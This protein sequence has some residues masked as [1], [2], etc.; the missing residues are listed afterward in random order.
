MALQLPKLQNP[1]RN[2]D[3]GVRGEKREPAKRKMMVENHARVVIESG[4][5][6]LGQEQE[7]IE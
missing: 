1:F 5:G 3:A 2:A 4:I 6:I 7:E